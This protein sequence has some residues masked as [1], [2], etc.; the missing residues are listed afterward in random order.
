M[1]CFLS[2][3][4]LYCMNC[5]VLSPVLLDLYCIDNYFI[6]FFFSLGQRH[7]AS[8][9]LVPQPRIEP[10]PSAVKVQSP[11]HCTAREFP[12]LSQYTWR[13]SIFPPP[14]AWKLVMCLIS[15]IQKIF[16]KNVTGM[17]NVSKPKI[18]E[19]FYPLS[20]KYMVLEN[21]HSYNHLSR[22]MGYFR[23]VFSFSFS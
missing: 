18:Q 22:F 15:I 14:I 5:F 6:S 4:D 19:Y 11:N 17:F 1:F 13:H 10:R 21:S 16:L 20:D 7:G 12:I 8:R 3:L 23:H 2:F 9:I